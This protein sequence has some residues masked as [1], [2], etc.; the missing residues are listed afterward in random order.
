MLNLCSLGI[1]TSIARCFSF[2]GPWLPK[3]EQYAIGNF[4]FDGF[5]RKKIEVK[6]NSRIFRSYMYA[7]DLICW[8]LKIAVNAKKKNC[9]IYNVG[10]DE[11]VS[12]HSVARLIGKILKKPLKI[13]KI[14]RNRIDRYIPSIEKAKKKLNLKINYNLKRSIYLTIKNS[15]M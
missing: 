12:V 8:L 6:S 15:N 4:L 10:S 5:K 7:D 13:K 2:I 14:N 3:N 11:V 9:Q 1:K